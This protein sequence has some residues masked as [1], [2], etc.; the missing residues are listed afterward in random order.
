MVLHLMV[1][2]TNKIYIQAR[3]QPHS[4]NIHTQGDMVYD[5]HTY[6]LS[7]GD[8]RFIRSPMYHFYR[9]EYKNCPA[10]AEAKFYASLPPKKS[11]IEKILDKFENFMMDFSTRDIN[12]FLSQSQDRFDLEQREKKVMMGNYRAV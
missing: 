2:K 9:V 10:D 8:D 11:F 3:V 7:E 5:T 4:S 1:L 6:L 12:E